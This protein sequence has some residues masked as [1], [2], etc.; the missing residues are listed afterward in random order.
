[1][2]FLDK[3][4]N[5][6]CDEMKK[7]AVR[8]RVPVEGIYYKEGNFLRPRDAE[9]DGTPFAPFDSQRMHWYGP[10]RHYWFRAEITVPESFAGRSLWLHVRTQIDEWDDAK[11]PQ[12]LL[13]V[14]DEIVQGMDMNHR[15]VLLTREAKAGERYRL[16]LQAYTG[17]LHT[18]VNLIFELRE[19]D[20]D[21]EGLYWDLYVP[22][23]AFPRLDP[24]DTRRMALERVMNDAVNLL[25]LRTPYS[26]AYMDTVRQARAYLQKHLYEELGGPADIIASCIGHTGIA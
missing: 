9:A 20:P 2:V 6:I 24:Q 25:D 13:F 4:I 1:M 7:Y 3:R 10:D 12:F 26:D 22:L 21:L 18:E 14:N 15:E 19:I 17:I 16:D 11:N 23:S 5:V 8:Q